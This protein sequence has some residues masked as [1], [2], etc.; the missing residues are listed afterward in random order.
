M[1][2]GEENTGLPAPICMEGDVFLACMWQSGCSV[3]HDWA[4]EKETG[5]TS[6]NFTLRPRYLCQN[7]NSPVF[8][9]KLL[10]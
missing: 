1:Y 3:L 6:I 10:L 5:I 8:L 2:V 4:T 9:M 7:S